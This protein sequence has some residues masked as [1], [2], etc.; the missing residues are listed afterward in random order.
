MNAPAPAETLTTTVDTSAEMPQPLATLGARVGLATA[1][2]AA[3]D[4]SVA[5]AQIRASAQDLAPAASQAMQVRGERG[6]AGQTAD[7]PRDFLSV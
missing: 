1:P 4:A 3:E 7:S 6:C 5:S 2:A